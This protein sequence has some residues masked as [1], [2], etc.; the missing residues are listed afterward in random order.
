LIDASESEPGLE[1]AGLGL[2]K[3]GEFTGGHGQDGL[4]IN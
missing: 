3:R 2:G 4:S 1:H